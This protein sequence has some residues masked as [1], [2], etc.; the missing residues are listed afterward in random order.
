MTLSQNPPLRL[1][2]LFERTSA[3]KITSEVA[4]A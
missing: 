1:R 4:H 3:L 2:P